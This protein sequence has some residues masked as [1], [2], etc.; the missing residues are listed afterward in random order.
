MINESEMSIEQLIEE[1]QRKE[2][3]RLNIVLR[4]IQAGVKFVDWK[5]V[6][7]DDGVSIGKGTVIEPGV[8]I[9]GNTRIGEGCTIGHNSKITDSTIADQVE[10]PMLRNC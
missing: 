1:E 10:N 3:E 6:Y 8:I 7:I 9:K 5:S 2:K 4:H